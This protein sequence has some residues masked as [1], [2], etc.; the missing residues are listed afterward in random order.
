MSEKEF[1][2][3]SMY[4]TGAVTLA[5][6]SLLTWNHYHGGIPSHH[7]LARKDLPEISNLWGAVLIPL[8]TGFLLYRI[9]KR[10]VRNAGGKSIATKSVVHVLYGFSGA[11]LFGILLA[12]FFALGYSDAT[13]YM[14]YGLFVLAFLFPIYRGE[15]ILGFVLGMTFTFGPVLPTGIGSIFAL[16]STVLYLYVRPGVLYVASSFRRLAK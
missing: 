13:G 16:I 9:K 4:F 2:K 10:L 7:I 5:M 11:L 8:L 12:V 3:T 15:C 1:F 14:F 6:W